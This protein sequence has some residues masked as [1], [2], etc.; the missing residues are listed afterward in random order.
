MSV[1]DAPAADATAARLTPVRLVE[2]RD[3]FV[4]PLFTYALEGAEDL[5]RRLM[6]DITRYRQQSPG[7]HSSNQHGWHSERDF[8]SRSE[9]SFVEL[10]RHIFT[11]I[12]ATV[13]SLNPRMDRSTLNANLQGWINVSER[14]AFNAP[15]DHPHYLLSGVY[16]VQVPGRN[17]SATTGRSGEIEFLD[18]RGLTLLAK[19]QDL[20]LG[21]AKQRLRPQAGRLLIFPSTLMHWVYPH[22]DEGE[23]VSIAFNM[24]IMPPKAPESGSGGGGGG[25]DA[26]PNPA[27]G[28][29]AA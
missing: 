4:T 10:K 5:N 16:Y 17:P 11:S 7:I 22:E 19:D 8:F 18:S 14:G 12:A 29:G 1:A 13:R 28:A 2:R 20:Y 25:A 26:Q 15:H 3:L 6:V 9:A 21:N 27:G 23:R 24:R